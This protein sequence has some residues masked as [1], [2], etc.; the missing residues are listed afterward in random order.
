MAAPLTGDKKA[1]FTG[2]IVGVI[3]L[4]CILYSIVLITNRHYEGAEQATAATT[5]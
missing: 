2:L 5:Q 3:V 1:G 4:F